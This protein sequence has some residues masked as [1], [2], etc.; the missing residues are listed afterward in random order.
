[1]PRSK[2]WIRRFV[3]EQ[4]EP[5]RRGPWRRLL[6]RTEQV[7]SLLG[8]APR[9]TPEHA[10][11]RSGE[12][13]AYWALREHGYTVIA[14][15]LRLRVPEGELDLIAYE[16]QPPELVFVEVKTRAREGQFLAEDAVDTAKRLRLIRLAR[17]WRRRRHYAG[18]YRFDMV[19]VYGPDEARP[20][21]TLHRRAFS[22]AGV[23]KRPHA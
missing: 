5:P 8:R 11:G 2:S 21:I 4:L 1:M 3:P 14:R 23:L 17:A 13:L 22:E 20:R 18:A 6:A 10:L 19:V 16:G 15:N 12:E 9:Q 7:A